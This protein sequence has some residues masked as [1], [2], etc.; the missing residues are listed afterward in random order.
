MWGGISGAGMRQQHP[1]PSRGFTMVELMVTLAVLAILLAMAVPSFRDFAERSALRGAADNVVGVIAAAKEE[2]VK[3]DSLVRVDFKEVGDGFCVGAAAVATTA[4][5]GCDCSST[6]CPVGE[7]PA[8]SGELRSVTLID[9][10]AFGGDTAFVIDPKTGMLADFTDTGG[11]ALQVPRGYGV[12][13][14]VNAMGRA[15]LCTPSKISDGTSAKAL[16]GIEACP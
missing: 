12:E 15:S 8:N 11:I 16:S 6:T 4:A 13:V 14:Q 1:Y 10:P 5:A 7:F 3:R 2:A 9:T